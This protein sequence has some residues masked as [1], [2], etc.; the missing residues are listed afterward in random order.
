M[1]LVQ[2]QVFEERTEILA[3]QLTPAS[4]LAH[5]PRVEG[6]DPRHGDD[7]GGAA[8]ERSHHMDDEGGAGK[9]Q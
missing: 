5:E 7:F 2:H 1:Q 6:V 8:S 3:P 9:A 4:M